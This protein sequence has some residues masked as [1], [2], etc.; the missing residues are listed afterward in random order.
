MGTTI[1]RYSLLALLV[2]SPFVAG[3]AQAREPAAVVQQREAELGRYLLGSWR[4]LDWIP[5]EGAS[6]ETVQIRT[7]ATYSAG[8]DLS[9]IGTMWFPTEA[10]D[11]QGRRAQ[12]KVEST[13]WWIVKALED[14]SVHLMGRGSTV[15]S[16][17]ASDFR[18]G[19]DWDMNQKIRI[20]DRD[21]Y[22]DADSVRWQ[23]VR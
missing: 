19:E 2:L 3:I 20:L 7:T 5:V 11:A 15:T 10:P 17:P 21:T 14:G 12:Y 22:M 16:N 13:G 6:P 8:N 9:S 18:M 4:N 23:R 1:I